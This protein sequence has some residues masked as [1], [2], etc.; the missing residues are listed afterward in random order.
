MGFVVQSG[1][2]TELPPEVIAA[3]EAPFDT[4]ESKAGAAM[5]P[6]LVP[7]SAGDPGAADAA[8]FLQEDRGE[9]VAE[10]ILAFLR[11]S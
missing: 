10:R 8:H 5:F 4:P 11:T 3:Y 7:L 6:L 2:K 9:E 1:S